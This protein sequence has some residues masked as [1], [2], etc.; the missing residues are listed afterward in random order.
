MMLETLRLLKIQL[1]NFFNFNEARYSRDP[2]KKNRLTMLMVVMT[3]V[4]AM[5]IF[6]VGIMAYS[7]CF[8]GMGRIVPAFVLAMTSVVI[9]FFTIFK[10]GGVMFQVKNYEMLISLPMRPSSIVVSRFLTMYVGNL[11]LTIIVMLPSAVIYGIFESIGIKFVLMMIISTFLLPLFPMTV[12]T[13]IGVIVLSYYPMLTGE[14]TEASDM[15]VL[16]QI[17]EMMTDKINQMYPIAPIFTK[18]V[19]DGDVCSFLIFVG[20]SVGIF[21]VLFALIS[22]KFVSICSAL[23]SKSARHNYKIGEMKQSSPVKALYI[24]E[25]RRYFASSIYVMNISISYIL[26]VILEIVI[27]VMGVDKIETSVNMPGVLSKIMPLMVATIVSITSI[28]S[29]SISLEGKQWYT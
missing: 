14:N 29:S 1:L 7:L 18:G 24:K 12:A 23:A 22:W 9:L 2:K 26:I 21:V 17:S 6:Y 19:V 28:T 13:V 20:L 4:G 27:C 3:F 8:M 10:A 15:M 25:F 11:L 5:V 16:S